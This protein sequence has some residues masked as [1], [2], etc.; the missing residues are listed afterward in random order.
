MSETKNTVSKLSV[1]PGFWVIVWLGTISPIAPVHADGIAAYGAQMC[2]SAGIPTNECTLTG[3]PWPAGEGLQASSGDEQRDKSETFLE[4]AR[5]RC[6]HQGIAPEDCQALPPTKRGD[7]QAALPAS[8]FLTVPEALPPVTL[9]SEPESVSSPIIVSPPRP[10]R[11]QTVGVVPPMRATSTQQV[12]REV[13]AL[14]QA[15]QPP[16]IAVGPPTTVQAFRDVGPPPQAF[17]P[18]LRDMEP[19]FVSPPFREVRP[20]TETIFPEF[21]G[22]PPVRANRVRAFREPRAPAGPAV[23]EA[24][25]SFAD[26]DDVGFFGRLF[27]GRQ[28]RCRREVRYSRPPSYRYVECF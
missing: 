10:A 5:S 16:F 24:R 23:R 1:L 2:E 9:A 21:R 18:V 17:Q 26:D 8:P 14:P 28:T 6:E 4:H 19:S 25:R 7:G 12:V 22:P 11:P 3:G 15:V 13:G 27:D 20:R